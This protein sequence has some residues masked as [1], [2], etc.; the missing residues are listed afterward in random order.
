[1][2]RRFSYIAT[3]TYRVTPFPSCGLQTRV[4]GFVASLLPSCKGKKKK[5]RSIFSLSVSRV[6]FPTNTLTSV[7]RRSTMPSVESYALTEAPTAFF[8]RRRTLLSPE[9]KCL[10]ILILLVLLLTREIEI[11]PPAFQHYFK[12]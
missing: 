2:Y 1:M 7:A 4:F 11:I 10:L 9:R 6:L 12:C 5:E 3:S 8:L